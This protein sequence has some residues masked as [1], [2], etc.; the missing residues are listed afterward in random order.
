MPQTN[1]RLTL[2]EVQKLRSVVGQG[3]AS[4]YQIA[5]FFGD[6][7]GMIG[8]VIDPLKQAAA[9][10]DFEIPVPAVSTSWFNRAKISLG[11]RHN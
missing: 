3:N 2:F 7:L 9:N 10:E 1:L 4:P 11:L 6:S 8:A 5:T